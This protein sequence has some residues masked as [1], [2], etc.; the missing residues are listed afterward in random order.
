MYLRHL[1]QPFFICTHICTIYF[2]DYKFETKSITL[3]HLPHKLLLWYLVQWMVW[4]NCICLYLFLLHLKNLLINWLITLFHYKQ[5]LHFSFRSHK[6][7]VPSI[8]VR[9]SVAT[10]YG[11][12]SWCTNFC[13]WPT[14]SLL[15]SKII[16]ITSESNFIQ[17]SKNPVHYTSCL[18]KI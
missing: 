7:Y 11:E 14:L 1:K 16:S 15:F 10:G 4:W 5:L 2:G 3:N 9:I 8:N 12:N 6:E 13:N 17:V 18:L